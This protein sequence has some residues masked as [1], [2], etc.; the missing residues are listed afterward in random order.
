[1][2]QILLQ[3]ETVILLRNETKVYCK[4]RHLF[5]YE[6]LN[7]NSFY[8]ILTILLQNASAVTKCNVHYKFHLSR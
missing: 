6:R 7:C 4:E 3:S 2:Q 8:K 5:H 1:M